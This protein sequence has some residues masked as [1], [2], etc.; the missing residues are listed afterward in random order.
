[1]ESD[2]L[3][4]GTTS[5]HDAFNQTRGSLPPV[6]LNSDLEIDDHSNQK[7][8]SSPKKKAAKQKLPT[9][10][11]AKEQ[12]GGQKRERPQIYLGGQSRVKRNVMPLEGHELVL[13]AQLAKNESAKKT[14]KKS[15]EPQDKI[16]ANKSNV[17]ENAMRDQTM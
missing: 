14:L 16:K 17:L 13:A 12:Y 4:P 2:K 6:T 1:M 10:R 7:K 3:P 11:Q 15:P 5:T 9:L 8:Q